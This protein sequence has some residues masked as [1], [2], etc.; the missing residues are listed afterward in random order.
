[1]NLAILQA[2]MSSTRLPGKIL[3]PILGRPMLMHQIDRIKRVKGI[4][5]LIVA[6]TDQPEDNGVEELCNSNGV[7]V[8]RGDLNDVLKRYYDAAITARPEIVT[9][10]TGDCPLF[11]AEVADLVINFFHTGQYDY[12]TNAVEPTYPDGLDLEVFRFECLEADYKNAQLQSEREHV[13]PWIRKQTQ[14]KIGH[15]KGPQD[16]SDLRWTVDEPR[17]FELVEMIY[18]HLYPEN[19]QFGY[20]DVLAYLEERSDL[21]TWN[22]EHKRN[23]GYLKS[24]QQDKQS[25]KS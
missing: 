13:T 16:W 24:L 8:F 4:D 7:E 5:R 12:A 1:M 20:R 11:D 21:K 3:K 6:T 10:L 17:D 15:F 18:N 19:P 2:R 14:Y 9:R 22:T 25:A 23:E